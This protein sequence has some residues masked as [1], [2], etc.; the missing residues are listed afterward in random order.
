MPSFE[1]C[2]CSICSTFVN[3]SLIISNNEK[4]HVIDTLAPEGYIKEY[5]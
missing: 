4:H 3:L 1:V 2:P 5:T